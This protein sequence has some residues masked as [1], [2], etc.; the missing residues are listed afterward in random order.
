[1]MERQLHS[2][3]ITVI[4][5][6][7]FVIIIIIIIIV[8]VIIIIIIIT[9]TIIVILLLCFFRLLMTELCYCLH[10]F[11]L[12]PFTCAAFPVSKGNYRYRIVSRTGMKTA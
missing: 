9:T 4:I 7:V 8:I 3:C 6:V 12:Y 5:T 10:F 1:M 2:I 11:M